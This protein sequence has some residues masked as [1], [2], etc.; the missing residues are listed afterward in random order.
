MAD[1]F[2]YVN[3]LLVQTSYRYMR[4]LFK[5]L[6]Y[7][8]RLVC[9]QYTIETGLVDC[10]DNI[11]W[12]LAQWTCYS[13]HDWWAWPLLIIY[14]PVST[15]STSARISPISLSQ[16]PHSHPSKWLRG[17]N[18]P[19]NDMCQI[20]SANPAVFDRKKLFPVRENNVQKEECTKEHCGRQTNSV[21][22]C[23]KDKYSKTPMWSGGGRMIK[24]A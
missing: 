3:I 15:Q 5:G 18:H 23:L 2:S 8:K 12:K 4:S 1:K 9:I 13:F 19:A 10:R 20:W 16:P 14:T 21:R 17:S 6:Q 11:E 22:A 24:D 7:V